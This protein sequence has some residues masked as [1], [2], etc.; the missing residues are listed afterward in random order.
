MK[1][2]VCGACERLNAASKDDFYPKQYLK[3][4]SKYGHNMDT[5]TTR[6]CSPIQLMAILLIQVFPGERSNFDFSHQKL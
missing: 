6:V 3:R 5:K 2:F 4:V 1:I